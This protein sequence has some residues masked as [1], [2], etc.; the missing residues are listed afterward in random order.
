VP[1]DEAL[2]ERLLSGDLTAFDVLYTRHERHLLGYIHGILGDRAEAED[3]LHEAFLALLRQGK[4]GRV[5]HGFRPWMYQTARNVSL[6][7]LRARGRAAQAMHL[8]SL[9]ERD[10]PAPDAGVETRQIGDRLGRAIARLPDELAQLF[11]LRAAG[12]SYEELSEV[13]AIPLGTVK[14]RMHQM[15]ERLRREVREVR[16]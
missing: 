13:L 8:T 14:S 4:A 11:R 2:F 16:R 15:V 10:S 12:L 1:S 3:V 9:E 7:R 5:V 6:N